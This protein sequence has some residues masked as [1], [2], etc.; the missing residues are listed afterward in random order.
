MA[1]QAIGP[2]DW[3]NEPITAPVPLP[4]PDRVWT[5]EEMDSIRLGHQPVSMDEK[6]FIYCRH[7]RLYLHRSWTGHGIYEAQFEKTEDGYR[8]AEAVVTNDPKRYRRTKTDNEE[9]EQLEALI[10]GWLLRT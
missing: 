6:W 2:D 8:I 5:R 9:S 4:A 7:D 3:K 1:P 10:A